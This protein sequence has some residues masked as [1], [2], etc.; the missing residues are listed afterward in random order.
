MSNMK[1]GSTVQLQSGAIMTV[2]K[3]GTNLDGDNWVECVWFVDG[4][5]K[6]CANFNQLALKPTTR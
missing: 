2:N 1:V 5:H 3:V 4:D 6:E